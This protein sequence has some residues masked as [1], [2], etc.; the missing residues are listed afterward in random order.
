MSMSKYDSV[1]VYI[2]HREA[3]ES[4][5]LMVDIWEKPTGAVDYDKFV[6]SK[7]YRTNPSWDYVFFHYKF[8]NP[9]NY[10]F[11]VYNENGNFNHRRLFTCKR[12][13]EIL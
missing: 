12:V 9:G 13:K 3:L 4:S 2:E 8:D 6:E 1:T 11:N 10:K 5:R 7:K